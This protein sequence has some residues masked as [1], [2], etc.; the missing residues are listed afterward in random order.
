M[1]LFPRIPRLPPRPTRP[2][3]RPTR[4]TQPEPAPQPKPT[5]SPQPKPTPK[6]K[7]AEQEVKPQPSRKS[8]NLTILPC[9]TGTR[10]KV[11]TKLAA[12]EFACQCQTIAAEI[13]FEEGWLAASVLNDI[14][15]GIEERI[16]RARLNR[17]RRQHAS[18]LRRWNQDAWTLE[19]TSEPRQKAPPGAVQ[20]VSHRI[21]K[22]M[23][24]VKP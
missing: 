12:A 5:P 14:S 24:P 9:G 22:P 17:L 6:P 23:P 19:Q 7:P 15:L 21:P 3:P 16:M 10:S 1:P 4:P 13:A 8:D 2:P 20:R 11:V 18:L